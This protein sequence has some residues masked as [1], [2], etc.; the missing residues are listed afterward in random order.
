MSFWATLLSVL[1]GLLG[2]VALFAWFLSSMAAFLWAF[3]FAEDGHTGN[4]SAKLWRPLARWTTAVLW[5]TL[6]MTVL[7]TVRDEGA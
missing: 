7:L 4:L 2:V 6:G 1:L 3:G 5:F